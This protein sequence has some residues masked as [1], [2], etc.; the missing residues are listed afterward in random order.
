MDAE[1]TTSR[2]MEPFTRAFRVAGGVV[3]ITLSALH[4]QNGEQRFL[5]TWQPPG[6]PQ[7]LSADDIA[8][9]D[10]GKRAAIAD[11]R[12]ALGAST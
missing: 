8:A 11:I 3:W 10:A 7:R 12:R 1:P 5:V 4:R 6:P 9:F 2:G